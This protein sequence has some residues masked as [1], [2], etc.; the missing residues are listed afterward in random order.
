MKT[1]AEYSREHR[2]R[3]PERCAEQNRDASR[4]RTGGDPATTTRSM[5]ASCEACGG[6][7]T[8]FRGGS[9]RLA[10]DHDHATGRFRGWLC[11]NCNTALGLLGESQVRLKALSKYLKKHK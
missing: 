2:K 8:R 1:R 11:S 5:P 3:H 10:W 4:R 9:E 7:P 6:A